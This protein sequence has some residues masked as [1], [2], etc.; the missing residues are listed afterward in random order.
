MGS[1][2]PSPV[3]FSNRPGNEAGR[4]VVYTES[5]SSSVMIVITLVEDRFDAMR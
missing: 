4:W 5:V 2:V 3:D 1:L